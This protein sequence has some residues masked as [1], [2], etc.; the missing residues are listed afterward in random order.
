MV[1][2]DPEPGLGAVYA[3]IE[4]ARALAVAGRYAEARLRFG[5]VLAHIARET[6]EMGD[7]AL[8]SRW[9]E[10]ARALGEEA[11]LAAACEEESAALALAGGAEAS[12]AP[13]AARQPQQPPYS[14]GGLAFDVHP[15]SGRLTPREPPPSQEQR[16]GSSDPDEQSDPLK[17]RPPSALSRCISSPSSPAPSRRAAEARGGGA[18]HAR[19]G[20]Y[21]AQGE[22]TGGGCA[23]CL[24]EERGGGE[25]LPAAGA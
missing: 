6:K 24:E 12:A 1:L 11:A 20:S 9:Q 17:W 14:G 22:R 3:Q 2:T 15:V 21:P 10:C 25:A 4:E 23:G 7:S 13:D 8:K 5:S 19:H 16:R 18:R